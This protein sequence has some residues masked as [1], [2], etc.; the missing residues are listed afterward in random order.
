[1]SINQLDLGFYKIAVLNNSGN[2]GKTT[3]CTNIL[4]PRILESEIIRIESQNYSDG[5]AQ[6]LTANEFSE[7]FEKIDA[8]DSAIIDIGSSNIEMFMKK[9]KSH[10]GSQHDIDSY[11][12]P[13]TPEHKQQID[14]V[15]TIEDLLSLDIPPEKIRIVFNFHSDIVAIDKEFSPLINTGLLDELG[16]KLSDIPVLNKSN[17]F[18]LLHEEQKSIEDI[19]NDET[20]YQTLIRQ[21]KDKEERAKY[22][23]LKVLKRLVASTIK[24]HDE[25]FQKLRIGE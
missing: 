11:I 8:V 4:K 24:E 22:S 16:L 23:A 1:M 13:T 3:I 5:I 6:T 10:E 20:D 21:T 19:M 7:I 17:A 9:I 14:T 2:V 12:I 15:S 18:Q 25:C